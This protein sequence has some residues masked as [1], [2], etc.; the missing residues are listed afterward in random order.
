[1]FSKYIFETFSYYDYEK[2]TDFLFL[3]FLKFTFENIFHSK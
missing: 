3:I 1:M 2:N